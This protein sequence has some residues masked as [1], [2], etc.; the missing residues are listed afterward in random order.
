M[1]LDDG[2]R[3]AKFAA[4]SVD[5]FFRVGVFVQCTIQQHF[6]RMPLVM[7]TYDD[8]G[9]A[10][11]FFSETRRQALRALLTESPMLYQR[12]LSTQRLCE[13]WGEISL[14]RA[15]LELPGFGFVKGGFLVQ[16]VYPFGVIG[17]LDR[18]NLALAGLK[19]DAFR[20]P[21]TT[22][23]LSHRLQVYYETCREFGG[24]ATLWD[25]WCTHLSKLRPRSFPT[26]DHVSKL[27]VQCI[28]GECHAREDRQEGHQA[29]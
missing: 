25:Q 8:E 27:H 17:C 4:Q 6:E 7:A 29:A 21:T 13:S 11:R 16:L 15:F 19:S 9:L 20:R 23:G 28:M 18:H 22:E 12:V 2:P 26:P 5:N 1:Y 10:S 24:S 14:L 3:I